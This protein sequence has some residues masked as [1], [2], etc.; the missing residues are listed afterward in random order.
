MTTTRRTLSSLAVLA[1]AAGLI[2]GCGDKDE[3]SPSAG[4]EATASAPKEQ[5][6]GGGGSATSTK[7]DV[8]KP[9]P[10]DYP[11]MDEHTQKGA[12]QAFRY[13]W[14]LQLWGYET[15][16]SAPLKSMSLES[17]KYCDSVI[18]DINDMAKKD[19]YWSEATL[20][21][22]DPVTEA[23]RGH[24][25]EVGYVIM[26]GEHEEDLY[27]NSKKRRVDS[28]EYVGAGA[29]NWASGKWSV[30]GVKIDKKSEVE[31]GD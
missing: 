13:F 28:V 4:S 23:S 27:G 30:A 8:P 31:N 3:P 9:D 14:A 19:L 24:D 7:P 20:K 25:Y 11:G 18:E 6:D 2:T 12:E 15:G 17:C 26:L 22:S 1:L 10:K 16:D 5:S 29:M 21:F